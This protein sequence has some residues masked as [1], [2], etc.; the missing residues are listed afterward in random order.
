MI[1]IN[2]KVDVFFFT[3]G[4]QQI[5]KLL[6]VPADFIWYTNKRPIIRTDDKTIVNKF[7]GSYFTSKVI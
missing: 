3:D 6:R 1:I 2:S 7:A 5:E 4:L